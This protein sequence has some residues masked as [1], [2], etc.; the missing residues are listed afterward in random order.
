MRSR[1]YPAD[2]QQIIR[3]DCRHA[4]GN[5]FRRRGCIVDCIH[6]AI[7]RKA[8]AR[9]IRK[10]YI[11]ENGETDSIAAYAPLVPAFKAIVRAVLVT[12]TSGLPKSLAY[13]PA[14]EP[15]V[16]ARGER[17][18]AVRDRTA[19]D[20]DVT[21]G[22]DIVSPP[23]ILIKPAPPGRVSRLLARCESVM[24]FEVQFEANE[25]GLVPGGRRTGAP[26]APMQLA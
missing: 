22:A 4:T 7:D 3:D 1:L 8:V 25:P 17:D 12:R 5:E 20:G 6:D 23:P 13:A 19:I 26:A 9:E 15:P 18:I 24:P 11:D 14:P 16:V 21:T 10:S 2:D